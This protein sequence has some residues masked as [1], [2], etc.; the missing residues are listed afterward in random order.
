MGNF[1]NFQGNVNTN[2]DVSTSNIGNDYSA[3]MRLPT[4]ANEW[5]FDLGDGAYGASFYL[6][7]NL[8]RYDT[9]AGEQTMLFDGTQFHTY[10]ILLKGGLVEYT[11]DGTVLY[12]GPASASA[13][14]W[15]FLIGDD[16][17]STP[18]GTG[19]LEIDWIN[20]D[21]TP[22]RNVEVVPEP[23]TLVFL[24]LAPV[25]MLRR[26]RKTSQPG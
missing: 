9:P 22:T 6:D 18:T 14:N 15:N 20:M 5:S 11:L 17:G 4:G 21:T 8:L 26:R 13:G 23:V 19:S 24:G 12:A 1:Q 7:F 2:W 10:G 16:S 25:A 3:R